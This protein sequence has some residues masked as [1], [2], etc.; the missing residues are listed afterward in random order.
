[1][2]I[3]TVFD[4]LNNLSV[5]SKE[6]LAFTGVFTIS[7][8]FVNKG[9]S[10]PMI[11]CWS[12]ASARRKIPSSHTGNRTLCMNGLFLGCQQI[13]LIENLAFFKKDVVSQN[14][15]LLS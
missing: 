7:R 12:P 3:R 13:R 5:R 14:G 9:I 6:M 8:G 4:F 1:L 2:E 11:L 15:K 10:S